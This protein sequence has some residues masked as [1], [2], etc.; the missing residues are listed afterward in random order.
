LD[1]GMKIILSTG[2][3]GTA[4]IGLSGAQLVVSCPNCAS[5]HVT[6]TCEPA[7]CG[8]HKCLEFEAKFDSRVTVIRQ[9]KGKPVSRPRLR[10]QGWTASG[11]FRPEYMRRT[12]LLRDYRRCGKDGH[13]MGELVLIEPSGICDAQVGW[14][15]DDCQRLR[16]EVGGFRALRTGFQFE[17]HPRALC[18]ECNSSYLDSA[19]R[20]PGRCRC[21]CCSA[22]LQIDL[23]PHES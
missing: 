8:V 20:Q 7:C 18:P 13:G 15:C 6:H 10:G 4:P 11:R 1:T 23:E 9:G 22:E 19:D 3:N 12:G 16:Y 17:A 14:Y 2:L 21:V 5:R